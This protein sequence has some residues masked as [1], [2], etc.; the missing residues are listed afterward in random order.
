M[1]AMTS[2]P[3]ETRILVVNDDSMVRF[4]IAANAEI[5]RLRGMGVQI[6]KRAGQNRARLTGCD[7]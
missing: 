4:N 5:D 6:E 1:T 7:S 2:V 3:A